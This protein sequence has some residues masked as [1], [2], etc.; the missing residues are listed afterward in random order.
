MRHMKEITLRNSWI[1][2]PPSVFP[3]LVDGVPCDD[4][5]AETDAKDEAETPPAPPPPP[6][7]P[8]PDF[9]ELE[10]PPNVL[11]SVQEALRSQVTAVRNELEEHYSK[12]S[13]GL[14]EQIA[15]LEKKK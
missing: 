14:E 2:L 6:P 1:E 12:R 5:A 7:P 3:S 10:L 15:R 4:A 8:E 13:A 11:Q 9:S